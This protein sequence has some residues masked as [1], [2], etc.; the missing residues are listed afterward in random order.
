MNKYQKPQLPFFEFIKL[1]F[2]ILKRMRKVYL[3]FILG[4]IA[5]FSSCMGSL[6]NNPRTVYYYN[7]LDGKLPPNFGEGENQILLI[8]KFYAL[9]KEGKVKRGI[10]EQNKNLYVV[11]AAEKY[12][13]G[14]FIF[15]DTAN[16]I[17]D[18]VYES[19]GVYRYLFWFDFT[20]SKMDDSDFYYHF[21][22]GILDRK[23]EV[24]YIGIEDSPSHHYTYIFLSYFNQMSLESLLKQ[25]K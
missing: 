13:S 20:R 18:Q 22:Y 2:N 24:E 8:K 11:K 25:K 14:N 17:I 21:E 1:G 16:C 3:F 19:K 5:I 4:V 15:V 23:T 7:V 10:G 12:Y 6:M 9:D